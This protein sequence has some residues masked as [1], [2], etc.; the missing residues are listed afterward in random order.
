MKRILL[1][2]LFALS[3]AACNNTE[4][5]KT[6]NK[7]DTTNATPS[8]ADVAKDLQEMADSDAHQADTLLK[9]LPVPKR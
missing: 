2:S 1:V 4:N 3:L 5:T 9:L 7:A 8:E 6:E